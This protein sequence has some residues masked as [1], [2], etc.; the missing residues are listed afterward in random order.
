ME[1]YSGGYKKG[2]SVMPKILLIIITI[3]VALILLVI[4][5]SSIANILFNQNVNKEVS[6]LFANNAEDKKELI[7]KSDLQGLPVCVQKWLDRSGVV[8]KE[9]IRTVRLKQKGLMRM[10]EGQPWMPAVA[11][12]YFTVDNPGFVWKVKV[13]M[14]PLIYFSGRDKYSDGKGKMLIKILSL[15][16]IVATEGGKEMNQGTALRYLAEMQWFP[17]AALSDYIKWEAIDSNS[18]R[19]IIS[20]GGV[21]ASGVFT[22]DGNGDLTSFTAKR[23]KEINGKY[24]LQDWGGLSNDYKEFNGIRIPSKADIFWREKTGDFIWYK[25]EITELE[26]NNTG[27]FH[28]PEVHDE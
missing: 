26:Y 27:H 24:V 13:N 15:Y 23:Y 4:I 8:G 20:Y 25:C 16:P 3:V 1:W 28:S 21:T 22:F 9:R 17:S 5:A 11:E 12:Q 18:A 7:N 2:G 6:D 19:A 10:K 14:A